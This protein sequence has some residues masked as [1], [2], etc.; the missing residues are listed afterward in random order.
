MVAFLHYCAK[1]L[2]RTGTLVQPLST[3][4]YKVKMQKMENTTRS[5]SVPFPALFRLRLKRKDITETTRKLSR[6]FAIS[7][8]CGENADHKQTV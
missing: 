5:P 7:C 4:V 8:W 2:A 6:V 3:P 1:F